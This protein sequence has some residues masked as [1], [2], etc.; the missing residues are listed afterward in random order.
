MPAVP[1]VT[2]APSPYGLR[3][4]TT[5]ATGVL[6][7]G[8]TPPASSSPAPFTGGVGRVAGGEMGAGMVGLMM[9]VMLVVM[10]V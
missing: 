7:S 1:T 2:S 4:G 6:P 9:M 8:P 5:F 3:R 10:G